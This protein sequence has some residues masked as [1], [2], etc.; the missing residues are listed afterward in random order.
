M[1]RMADSPTKRPQVKLY[2]DVLLLIEMFHGLRYKNKTSFMMLKCK[3]R[4]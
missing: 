1:R 4:V 3:C 2:R